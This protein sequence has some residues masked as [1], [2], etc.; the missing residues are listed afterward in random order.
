MPITNTAPISVNFCECKCCL[1]YSMSLK[2]K[3]YHKEI[4]RQVLFKHYLFI[5]PLIIMDFIL[6][7]PQFFFKL[8]FFNSA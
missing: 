2:R 5:C 4:N 7:K 8:C 3:L 1:L 6:T